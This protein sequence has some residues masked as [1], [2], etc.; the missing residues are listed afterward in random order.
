MVSFSN[1]GDTNS[2]NTGSGNT[3]SGNPNSGEPYSD[4]TVN[5]GNPN[6][7]ELDARDAYDPLDKV[8]SLFRSS[9][10]QITRYLRRLSS[11]LNDQDIDDVLAKVVVELVGYWNTRNQLPSMGWLKL[12]AR[13]RALPV[14]RKKR[15]EDA[16]FS[17]L[18]NE[19]WLH[20]QSEVETP[21]A[22]VLLDLSISE[23]KDA[24][25]K[26]PPIDQEILWA[27]VENGK[28]WADDLAIIMHRSP[29][30]LRK[31]RERALQKLFE[32]LN[33]RIG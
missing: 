32:I 4:I 1:S 9:E 28:G 31:R 19:S 24:V 12:T 5:L 21:D 18:R 23:M 33:P 22:L 7:G 8:F 25:L 2:G 29:D 3:G 26:L 17:A 14:I 15:R 10:P 13:N 6:P 30:S 27:S 20:A 16:F 11:I